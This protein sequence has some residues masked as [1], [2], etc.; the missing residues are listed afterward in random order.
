MSSS[1]TFTTSI[2][3]HSTTSGVCKDSNG[4]LYCLK[5]VEDSLASDRF[6]F[7]TTLKH[8][9][10]LRYFIVTDKQHGE[11]AEEHCSLGS[12]CDLIQAEHEFSINDLWC[13]L[14]Q[15]VF[16]FDFLLKRQLVLTELSISNVFISSFNPLCIKLS[17][18]SSTKNLTYS[19]KGILIEVIEDDCDTTDFDKLLFEKLNDFIRSLVCL[20]CP[21]IFSKNTPFLYLDDRF[22]PFF[23]L[24]DN[25]TTCSDFD[26]LK[27]SSKVLSCVEN[28]FSSLSVPK[29]I[30]VTSQ[31]FI[32]R[33]L[34]CRIFNQGILKFKK[35]LFCFKNYDGE[36]TCENAVFAN[37]ANK[38]INISTL[39]REMFLS[40]FLS[41]CDNGDHLFSDSD[42]RSSRD[43]LLKTSFL[44]SCHLYDRSNLC[45]KWLS[46][47]PV[48]FISTTCLENIDMNI[49]KVS[50]LDLFG[51]TSD[52]F[53]LNNYINLTSFTIHNISHLHVLDF[54]PLSYCHQLSKLSLNST[55][56]CILDLSLLP[57]LEQLSSLALCG[58]VIDD[59]SPIVVFSR[60]TRLSLKNSEFFD[61]LPLQQLANLIFLDLRETTLSREHR[62]IVHGHGEI[63]KVLSSL[64][65][66]TLLD[67]TKFDPNFIIELS[68]YIIYP[69]LK[70]LILTSGKL[71]DIHLISKFTNLEELDLSGSL[72]FDEFEPEPLVDISF[73]STCIKLK[74]LALNNT[75]VSDLTVL[76][77]LEEV[78]YLSLNN[79][80]VF[81]LGPLATLKQLHS[82]YLRKSRVLDLWPL[83]SLTKLTTLDVRETLLPKFRQE[84][85]SGF[86][87]VKTLVELFNPES[88]FIHSNSEFFNSIIF[89]CSLIPRS[90]RLKN[91]HLTNSCLESISF[92]SSLTSIQVLNLSGVTLLENFVDNFKTSRKLSTLSFVSSCVH[93]KSLCI[94]HS[95]IADLTPL[96]SLVELESL[97]LEGTNVFELSPLLNLTKL[98][99]L[100]VRFTLLPRQFQR[101]LSNSDL[102]KSLIKNL[103]QT[104]IDLC[105]KNKHID[106]SLFTNG[107]R[108]ESLKLHSCFV[109][110]LPCFSLFTNLEHLVLSNVQTPVNSFSF[111][112]I[113]DFSFLSDCVKLQSLDIN[114]SILENLGPLSSLTEL[115]RLSLFSTRVYD[116]LPLQH[117]TKLSFL[118]VRETQL[119]TNL[120][121]I[122]VGSAEI[123]K[124]ISK[125]AT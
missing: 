42:C 87:K 52:L 82:L 36:L 72:L 125:F 12:L 79:C 28:Y 55:K 61:L 39:F 32:S 101:L 5:K 8:P 7:L 90:T 24:I 94:D 25:V 41:C 102:V 35:P 111:E 105:L 97:S 119:P 98:S 37:F 44:E 50:E 57:N 1:I 4:L 86:E 11:I 110:N 54:S 80:V 64:K 83:I 60:L 23:E 15:L 27:N 74:S 31:L 88:S 103:Q 46:K 92:L 45:L 33:T 9:C 113:S 14:T 30:N 75:G 112:I 13:I 99:F 29:S 77:V 95:I 117:L 62:R 121:G 43:Y 84:F 67:L 124:L 47:Y 18:I 91:L 17:L 76:T 68:T 118:D 109:T 58:F 115:K 104:G 48:T 71:C 65:H 66:V 2:V 22:K 123:K 122:Y 38:I 34:L 59:L 69:F 21:G 40:V 96:S 70:T 93:L 51:V 10:F 53:S 63:L 26:L 120:K 85:L 106:L 108:V 107:F 20:V 16:L 116:L 73:L 114:D 78:E 81:D 49:S 56:C 89:D 19:N 100:D 6:S 3:S